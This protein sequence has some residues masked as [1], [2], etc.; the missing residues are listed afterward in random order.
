MISRRSFPA[1][2]CLV[3]STVASHGAGVFSTATLTGDASSGITADAAFTHAIN[4]YDSGN[5]KVN[6][7]VFTGSGTGT[8]PTTNNYSTTGFNNGFTGFDALAN[9]GISG[10]VGGLMTNFLYNGNP[11]T[12]T[13]RNLRVGQ[14]YEAVFYNAAFGG[15]GVRFQTITASDG[16]SVVFDQNGQPGSLLRYL[17][18]ATGSTLTLSITPSVPGNTF[19]QYAFSNRAVGLQAL[20]TDNF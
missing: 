10:S 6:G 12:V 20:F 19:H 3:I 2:L 4:V 1:L 13:L 16:G 9:D 15:P 18:T 5:A 7:A 8:N 11:A 17:F 14:Q